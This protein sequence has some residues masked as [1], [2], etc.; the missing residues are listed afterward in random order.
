ML[1]SEHLIARSIAV[2]MKS[3]SG[4]ASGVAL[5]LSTAN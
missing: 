1:T 2:A 5:G 4:A 3:V